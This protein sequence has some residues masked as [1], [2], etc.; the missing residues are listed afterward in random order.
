MRRTSGARSVR[1]RP[2][3]SPAR[4]K[5]RSLL[6]IA[7]ASRRP[8]QQRRRPESRGDELLAAAAALRLSDPIALEGSAAD[9]LSQEGNDERRQTLGI[10]HEDPVTVSFE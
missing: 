7:N 2:S 4:L 5:D 8:R 6:W 10:L 3:C 1:F 9:L